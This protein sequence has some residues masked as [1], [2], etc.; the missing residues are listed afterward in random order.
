MIRNIVLT[1]VK[2]LNEIGYIWN[3]PFRAQLH[4]GIMIPRPCLGL[5]K[6]GL[7]PEMHTKS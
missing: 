4:T 5:Y 2:K 3:C 6:L 1:V 7:Q